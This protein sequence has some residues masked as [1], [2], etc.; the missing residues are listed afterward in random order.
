MSLGQVRV[1]WVERS[2]MTTV[3]SRRS[4]V[5]S[6]RSTVPSGPPSG[7]RSATQEPDPTVTEAEA[8]RIALRAAQQAVR[9]VLTLLPTNPTTQAPDGLEE[10]VERAVGRVLRHTPPARVLEDPK[11]ASRTPSS[12]EEPI[13]IPSNLVSKGDETDLKLE[14]VTADEG[15]GDAAAAL[16]ALRKKKEKK[17][18]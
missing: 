15:V 11:V 7:T 10:L 4:T 5:P 2:R 9:E 16:K 18:E 3:P 8:E 12:V 6:R 14:S 13:Y 1:S 17:D